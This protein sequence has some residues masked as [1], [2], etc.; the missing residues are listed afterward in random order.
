MFG[1]IAIMLNGK[2][3][4]GVLNDDLVARIGAERS[5]KALAKPHVR[6]MDFSGRVMKGYVYVGPAAIKDKRSL[7][8]WLDAC[9]AHTA[10]L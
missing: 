7:Q 8:R 2:M 5:A 4:C 3:C 10:T 1:G 9:R 6:A